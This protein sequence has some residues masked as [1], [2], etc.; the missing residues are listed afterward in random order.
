MVKLVK[1]SVKRNAL[2]TIVAVGIGVVK[3]GIVGTIWIVAPNALDSEAKPAADFIEKSLFRW[4]YPLF[5]RDA[6]IAED[7]DYGPSPIIALPNPCKVKLTLRGLVAIAW[8]PSK[9]GFNVQ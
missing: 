3:I 6:L 8:H 1:R 5:V 4:W 7:R 9:N 2:E